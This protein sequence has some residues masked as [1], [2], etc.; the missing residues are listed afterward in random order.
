[1][2]RGLR[3]LAWVGTSAP[4]LL[5]VIGMLR[6]FSPGRAIRG[7]C[8]NGFR[9]RSHL[10][11][12]GCRWVVCA[13]RG[14]RPCSAAGCS[15]GSPVVATAFSV[16]RSA[17][18]ADG[19]VDV[20][21]LAPLPGLCADAGSRTG[22][23]RRI[24]V[25]SGGRRLVELALSGG[26]L[27]QPGDRIFDL[28]RGRREGDQCVAWPLDAAVVCGSAAAGLRPGSR[29]LNAVADVAIGQFAARPALHRSS[30]VGQ[31]VARFV[32]RVSSSTKRA[33]A[34]IRCLPCSVIRPSLW[35]S[36]RAG[37]GGA[38]CCWPA[39]SAGRCSRMCCG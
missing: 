19:M 8:C 17:A 36:C 24:A 21:A 27:R 13:V 14:D 4:G 1:M 15:S 3:V 33:A 20:A 22:A 9:C 32:R 35:C 25:R 28:A 7:G 18:A 2:P 26:D 11:A 38:C 16:R 29:L 37:S 5:Q 6:I 12:H 23:A 39:A 34:C 31:R 30:H 10:A